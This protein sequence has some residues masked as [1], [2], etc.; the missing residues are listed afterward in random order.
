[1]EVKLPRITQVSKKGVMQRRIAKKLCWGRRGKA[2][3]IREDLWSEESEA[4]RAKRQNRAMQGIIPSGQSSV[5]WH[6]PS[7]F[8]AQGFV[9]IHQQKIVSILNSRPKPMPVF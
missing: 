5:T 4:R 1:M 2:P 6:R 7:T 9:A 3:C 8:E